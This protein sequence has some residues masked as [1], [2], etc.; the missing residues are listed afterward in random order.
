MPS[1]ADIAVRLNR[2]V[3]DNSAAGVPYQ[4]EAQPITIHNSIQADK[5]T[6][7]AD[8][9]AAALGT[10]AKVAQNVS[11][12]QTAVDT[13]QGTLD[14]DAGVTQPNASTAY[15]A[16]QDHVHALASWAVDGDRIATDLQHQG[17]EQNPDAK[18]GLADMNN[19]LNSQF[20]G[21]YAGSSNATAAT[22]APKMAELRVNAN[23]WYQQQQQQQLNAKQQGDL[24]TITGSAFS[25]AFVPTI[26]PLT[27]QPFADTNG[28]PIGG[29][30]FAPQMFDYQG[31]NSNY[32]SLYPG[33]AGNHLYLSSLADLAISKGSPEL[34]TNMPDHWADGTPTPKG[35]GDP[36]VTDQ[37]RSAVKQAEEQKDMF[38]RHAGAVNDVA[39]KAIVKNAETGIMNNIL[40]AKDQTAALH[41]YATLPGADP[42][43][44]E[45]AANWQHERFEQGQAAALDSGSS[46]KIIGDIA[47]NQITT[48]AQILDAVT[49]ANLQGKAKADMLTKALS[50]LGEVQKVGSDDPSMK[51]Y[52]ADLDQRYKPGTDPLTGKFSNTAAAQQHADVLLNYRRQVIAGT[53][54]QDAW[55]NVQKTAGAPIELADV[56]PKIRNLTPA[57]DAD[58]AQVVKSAD[59]TALA[60]AGVTGSDL[61]R[62]RDSGQISADEAAKA[63][64]V[65]LA[66]R[67]G[68]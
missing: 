56:T 7:M 68:K 5:T 50:T 9:L 28:R 53:A 36:T 1:P 15:T 12:K 31:V 47:S 60:S 64:T 29:G 61:R 66:H 41:A 38:L 16:A 24:K 11:D 22:I 45:K 4:V 54:P 35:S 19:W 51:A 30:S 14:A 46:A 13:T 3:Q 57:N 49:A 17:F 40:S 65:L 67:N 44:L 42:S 34:L 62:L 26:D 23:A 10:G 37:Y 55:T 6:I 52:L 63:A 48:P 25:K 39:Q 21:M 18:Q 32:Q 33:A 20:Q 8:Q 59:P 58:R 2:T 43:F 27:G